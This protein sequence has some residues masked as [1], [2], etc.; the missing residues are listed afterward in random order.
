[1]KNLAGLENLLEPWETRDDLLR[2]PSEALLLKWVNYHVKKG[3][4]QRTAK[5]FKKDF[6]D[7]EIYAALLKQVKLRNIVLIRTNEV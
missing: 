2:M 6:Q 3:G 7:S 4:S 5:N 1:M